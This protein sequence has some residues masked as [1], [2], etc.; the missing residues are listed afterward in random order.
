MRGEPSHGAFLRLAARNGARSPKQFASALG[1]SWRSILAGHHR[2]AIEAWAGLAPGALIAFSVRPSAITRIVN[3]NSENIALGDWSIRQRRICPLCL[4]EDC[5]VAQANRL[6]AEAVVHHRAYWDVQS[7]RSCP[8]HKLLLVIECQRC[9]RQLGWADPAVGKCRSGCDLSSATS[10]K[11]SDEYD[12]YLASRLGFG[13][14]PNLPELDSLEYRHAVRF[15]ELLGL[16]KLRGWSEKLPRRS[17]AEFAAAGSQGFLISKDLDRNLWPLLDQTIAGSAAISRTNG[18][19]AA[20]GWVYTHW[21]SEDLPVAKAIQSILRTHAVANGVIATQEPILGFGA[22][23]TLSIQ[24]I[25]AELGSGHNSTRRRLSAVGLIP[26]A[27]RRG[28][29]C[30]IDP[31]A[32]RAILEFE[33]ATT[34]GTRMIGKRLGVGRGCARDLLVL[35]LIDEAQGVVSEQA[36][37]DFSK[38]LLGKCRLTPPSDATSVKVAAKNRNIRLA[39]V[40]CA[41]ARGQLSAWFAAPTSSQFLAERL[42]VVPSQIQIG[43]DKSIP[44]TKAARILS[45]HPE[46]VSEFVKCGKLSRANGRGLCAESIAIFDQQFVALAPLARARKSA[47]RALMRDLVTQGVKPAFAPPKFRQVLYRRRDLQELSQFSGFADWHA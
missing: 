24:Q 41:I 33:S 21:A 26:S 34:L 3:L 7:I 16:L 29:K 17:T 42:M 11:I 30:A 45:L 43:V 1:L 27:T 39:H 46:A 25:R 2:E 22:S 14:A 18:I 8:K 38:L 5:Q 47:P 44:V 10:T 9:H 13:T 15:C 20:Y 6:P 12:Q 32:I 23:R 31:G 35:G 37:D 4:A 28:V 19:I 40:L 36:L